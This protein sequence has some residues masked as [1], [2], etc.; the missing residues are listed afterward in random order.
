MTL[1]FGFTAKKSTPRLNEDDQ[2]VINLDKVESSM[3]AAINALKY[4]YTNSIIT[5]ITPGIKSL[6]LSLSL[7]CIPHACVHTHPLMYRHTVRILVYSHM[8]SFAN[9]RSLNPFI[10]RCHACTF[11]VCTP[12]PWVTECKHCVYVEN[13]MAS[14]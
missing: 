12:L 14:G 5:R 13:L 11:V 6:S 7:L 9:P 4:E 10:S 3:E 1:F 8:S 2:G